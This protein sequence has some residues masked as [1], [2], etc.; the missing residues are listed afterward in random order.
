MKLFVA[1]NPIHTT[2]MKNCIPVLFVLTT[3]FIGCQKSGENE[4]EVTLNDLKGKWKFVATKEGPDS[5][6]PQGVWTNFNYGKTTYVKELYCVNDSRVGQSYYLSDINCAYYESAGSIVG[7]ISSDCG[8][9]IVMRDTVWT[10]LTA[11]DLILK[12]ANSFE[13]VEAYK[14]SKYVNLIKQPCSTIQYVPESTSGNT[15]NGTWTFDEAS[16]MISVD[17]GTSVNSYN[18]EQQSKFKVTKFA[19]STVEL[20]LQGSVNMEFRL[21]KQ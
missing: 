8:R 2:F 17:F 10:Q 11:Y 21:Q 20:Q 13:W 15:K 4:P 16:Q 1:Y 9:T 6:N 18:G 19:G 5:S 7:V 12:D 3:L 14:H